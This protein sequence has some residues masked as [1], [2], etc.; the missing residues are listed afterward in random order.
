M[1]NFVFSFAIPANQPSV[2][3]A[4]MYHPGGIVFRRPQDG[5]VMER[6]R[7]ESEASGR[8]P[9]PPD[10]SRHVNEAGGLFPFH[11]KG[12]QPWATSQ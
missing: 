1:I 7:R 10:T 2:S 12:E 3:T 6:K 9:Y 8:E 4:Q 5:S 11:P